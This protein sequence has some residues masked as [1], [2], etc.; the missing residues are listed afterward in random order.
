M[1]ISP[2]ITKGLSLNE[3]LNQDLIDNINESLEVNV[4]KFFLFNFVYWRKII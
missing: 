2:I 4:L 1:E 3:L